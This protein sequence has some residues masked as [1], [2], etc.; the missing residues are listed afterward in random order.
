MKASGWWDA[1]SERGSASDECVG[2]RRREMEYQHV[3]SD[4]WG[5]VLEGDLG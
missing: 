2:E 1:E 5:D 3:T 4:S